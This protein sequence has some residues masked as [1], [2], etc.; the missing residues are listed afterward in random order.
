LPAKFH[1]FSLTVIQLSLRA[2][3][4]GHVS[5]RAM[6]VIWELFEPFFGQTPGFSSVRLWL[7][8]VGVYLWQRRP[9]RQD[10]W[11]FLLDHV[12][13]FTGGKCLLIV[14]VRRSALREGHFQLTHHDVTVLYAEVMTSSTGVA[15]RAILGDLSA[16]A[17]VPV[18]VVSDHGSDVLKGERLFQAEHPDLVLTWDIT[19]RLARLWLAAI[20]DDARWAS[21]REQCR[22]TRTNTERTR[23][24]FLAP[25]AQ[26]GS[27]RC[28]HFDRLTLWG[29]DLLAYQDRGDFSAVNPG[30]VWDAAAVSELRDLPAELH[31]RLEPLRD[32]LHP[33]R[34][35][36]AA[37]ASQALGGE[38]AEY[39]SAVLRAGDM[40]RREFHER[41]GWVES[42]RAELQEVYVPLVRMGYAAEEQVKAEGFHGRTGR[43]W[44]AATAA[45][46]LR[47]GRARQFAADLLR[48]LRAEGRGRRP[49]EALLGTTD[50]LESLFGKYK[51]YSE[52]GPLRELGATLLLL[53]LATVHL[54]VDLVREAL[55]AVRVKTLQGWQRQTFG[56]STLGQ[57][58]LAFSSPADTKPS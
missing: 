51:Q 17:G 36:F 43:R 38:Q 4:A 11:I 13:E 9:P 22:Q 19:H 24:R 21:F 44:R 2:V 3:L 5:L 48:Y 20:R 27:T 45:D 56:L 52:R 14:G 6:Q 58:R 34:A 41:F 57:H 42:F 39:V 32:R 7:Y 47:H 25:P 23:L 35:T 31:A 37:A 53:P 26:T 12:A 40:G 54:T 29:A 55:A 46:W 16:V 8:R 28:E 33:D 30:H 50:V 10:D 49:E 1:G 15:I 18:Q